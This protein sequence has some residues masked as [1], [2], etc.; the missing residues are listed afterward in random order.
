MLHLIVNAFW[1]ALEFELPALMEGGAA[2]RRCLDTSLDAPADVCGWN[3][4]PSVQARTYRAHPRSVVVL[5]A[6]TAGDL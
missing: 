1:E 6:R 5:V 2:W 3:D 4:A